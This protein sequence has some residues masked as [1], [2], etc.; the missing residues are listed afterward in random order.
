[1]HIFSRS[2]GNAM[3]DQCLPCPKGYGDQ[4]LIKPLTVEMPSVNK[5]LGSFKSEAGFCAEV[6]TKDPKTLVDLTSSGTSRLKIS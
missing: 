4:R 1:M 6:T 3:A 5:T 2:P